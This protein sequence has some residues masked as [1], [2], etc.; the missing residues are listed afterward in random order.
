MIDPQE[1]IRNEISLLKT[2]ADKQRANFIKIKGT[3]L[4]GCKYCNNLI[5]I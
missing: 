4:E 3:E 1:I 2:C 5:S